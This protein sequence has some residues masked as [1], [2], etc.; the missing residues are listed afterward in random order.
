MNFENMFEQDYYSIDILMW[1]QVVYQLLFTYDM[2][3]S[4][5]KKDIVINDKN[6]AISASIGVAISQGVDLDAKQMVKQADI[7]MYKAKLAGKNQFILA[8]E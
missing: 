7:A 3:S 6:I 1:T 4:R 8:D 5:I 2:G